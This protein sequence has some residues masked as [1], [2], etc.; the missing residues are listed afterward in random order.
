[1][2]W[3]MRRKEWRELGIGTAF[4]LPNLLGFL[5][6][7]AIPLVISIIMAFTNWNLE[8]HNMF[9]NA[10]VK[11]VWFDNFL[12][13]FSEPDFY[14]YL[15]NTLFLM[16]GIPFGMAGSLFAALLLNCD[17]KSGSRRIWLIV[18]LTFVLTAACLVL[19]AFGMGKS[20]LFILLLSL[21]GTILVAGTAVGQGLYRTLFYFPC[22]TSGVATFILWKK[23]YSPDTG[24][25]N[26]ALQPV[27]DAVSPVFAGLSDGAAN[28]V[29]LVLLAGVVLLTVYGFRRKIRLWKDGEAGTVSLVLGL[30]VLTVPP[31]LA[32]C[33]TDYGCRWV[34]FGIVAA[35]GWCCAAAAVARGREYRT[36]LD[37]G[38]G[39]SM[40]LDGISMI[41]G[42]TLIGFAL[43]VLQLPADARA[44][45][46]APKWL[47]DF[48]W[49]K[50][51]LLLM[52]FWAAIGSNNM[53]L[54]L[55]GLT[56]IPQEL[57]EA[58]DIDG[59][60]RWQRFWN[61]TWPQLSGVTFFIFVMSVIGGLQGGFEMARAMTAGGPAGATT[62]LSYYIYTAGFDVGRLG[63]AS[64]ISWMLFALIFVVT[65]FNWKF[66]NRYSND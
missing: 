32:C 28:A 4:I 7:S 43:V 44:G 21:F 18:L 56:G 42:L 11:F 31:V 48:Y 15:W 12:E 41:V 19:V 52:G 40:L 63:Y 22:F 20:A 5:V 65:L 34:V 58:A 35:G 38:I 25:I 59:A 23:M 66:G 29:S 14:Q 39:D 50:P 26:G 17:F 9:Q 46:N 8:I 2:K 61:I 27:L 45:L 60:G 55:A 53:L 6:F 16:I 57:Y 30:A 37:R 24:P 3:G 64:A 13:L 33:W 36:A 49:A 54:Y 51:A 47:V 62:T 1:M 10:S